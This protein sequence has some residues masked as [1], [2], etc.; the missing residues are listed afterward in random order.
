[1]SLSTLDGPA[2]TMNNANS[3]FIPLSSDMEMTAT[4]GVS[5]AHDMHD[6]EAHNRST[7]TTTGRSITMDT[8]RGDGNVQTS[9]TANVANTAN[10][11]ETAT[12]VGVPVRDTTVMMN[13]PYPLATATVTATNDDHQ[14]GTGSSTYLPTA[15]AIAGQW[16]RRRVPGD[17]PWHYRSYILTLPVR[18]CPGYT[19]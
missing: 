1:M 4:V 11:Y 13:Y 12:A 7:G 2:A 17:P 8:S 18:P 9:A 14:H 19:T 10:S 3:S 5:T 6:M 15:S 16:A